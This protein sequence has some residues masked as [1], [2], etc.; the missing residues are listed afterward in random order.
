MVDVECSVLGVAHVDQMC[1]PTALLTTRLLLKKRG[2]FLKVR[3]HIN[4]FSHTCVA[5]HGSLI[6][7]DF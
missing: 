3:G 6:E 7:E 5:W 4:S 2:L 1:I